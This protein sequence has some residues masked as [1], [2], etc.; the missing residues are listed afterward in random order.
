[1]EGKIEVKIQGNNTPESLATGTPRHSGGWV[2]S[3]EFKVVQ[4]G[5]TLSGETSS[6]L[7]VLLPDQQLPSINLQTR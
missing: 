5:C 3:D 1:V 6:L 4:G 2:S 7:F